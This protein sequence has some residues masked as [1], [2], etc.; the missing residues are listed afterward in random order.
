VSAN[1]MVDN[2]LVTRKIVNIF[3]S[4]IIYA[5]LF[6]FCFIISSLLLYYFSDLFSWFTKPLEWVFIP[7]NLL[8][9]ALIYFRLHKRKILRVIGIVWGII[10]LLFIL[11]IFQGVTGILN[12][13]WSSIDCGGIDPGFKSG[14]TFDLYG[15]KKSCF[16]FKCKVEESKLPSALPNL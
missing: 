3:L 1:G 6:T 5:G 7:F 9:A 8:I 2:Q 16:L 13:L 15:K 4:L 14:C 10:S 11:S 12:P